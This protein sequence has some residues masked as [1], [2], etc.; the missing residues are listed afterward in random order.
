MIFLC[1]YYIHVVVFSQLQAMQLFYYI[2]C[3][4]ACSKFGIVCVALGLDSMCYI[5]YGESYYM[6]NVLD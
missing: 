1:I 2:A 3:L 4:E 5:L 6:W